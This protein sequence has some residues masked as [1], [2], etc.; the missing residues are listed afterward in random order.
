MK[1]VVIIR[2]GIVSGALTDSNEQIDVEVLGIDRDYEDYD[3]LTEYEDELYKDSRFHPVLDCH[4]VRFYEG[5]EGICE[6]LT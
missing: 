5:E 4:S 1:V 2:D 6:G 3:S